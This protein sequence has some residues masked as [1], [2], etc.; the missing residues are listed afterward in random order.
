VLAF[1]NGTVTEDMLGDRVRKLGT[2]AKTLRARQAELCA[3]MGPSQ[4]AFAI[5][6]EID[7]VRDRSEAVVER[8]SAPARKALARAFVYELRVKPGTSC[9]PPTNSVVDSSGREHGHTGRWE[10]R[11]SHNDTYGVA[12][13]FG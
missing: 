10:R 11:C 7:V 3:A 4:A 8:G 6:A 9:S 13:R 12:G 2:Q 1:E 5:R